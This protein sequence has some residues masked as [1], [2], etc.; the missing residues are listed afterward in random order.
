MKTMLKILLFYALLLGAWQLVAALRVLP[1]YRFPSPAA[2]VI[3]LQE[4]LLDGALLPSIRATLTRMLIGFGTAAILGLAIGIIMGMRPLIKRCFHSLCV[5]LQTLP[6]VAW[7]PIA[8][9]IFGLD[10]KGIYFVII[11]S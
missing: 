5:G 8:L 7:V 1:E 11:M 10:D 6:S 3:R 2:V 9:L 4:L